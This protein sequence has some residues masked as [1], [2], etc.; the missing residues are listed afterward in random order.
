V[1]GNLS[2]TVYTVSKETKREQGQLGGWVGRRMVRK[3]LMKV[4]TQIQ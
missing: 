2:I 3:G 4:E 1:L